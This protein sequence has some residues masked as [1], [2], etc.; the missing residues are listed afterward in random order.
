MTACPKKYLHQCSLKT[1]L[2]YRVDLSGKIFPLSRMA[3]SSNKAFSLLFFALLTVT[4]T[5]SQGI[6]ANQPKSLVSFRPMHRHSPLSDRELMRLRRK[7]KAVVN[8]TKVHNLDDSDEEVLTTLGI[9]F[10]AAWLGM[11]WSIPML[12][13]PFA[14]LM[15][16]FRVAVWFN[17]LA[18]A[19]SKSGY[20]LP[21]TFYHVRSM[22]FMY[23][24][25]MN[26][27]K[28]TCKHVRYLSVCIPFTWQARL[29]HC[30]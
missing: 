5:P 20:Y 30:D 24:L 19:L 17:L 3:S 14:V 21:Q 1:L 29:K 13:A 28:G 12:L 4:V 22:L 2:E 8:S 11:I 10:R 6:S 27:A 23:T 15:K 9:A 18:L 16:P 7:L 25:E 26:R